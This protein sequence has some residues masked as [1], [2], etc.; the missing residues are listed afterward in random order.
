[1][2]PSIPWNSSVSVFV[3][4][5]TAF[6]HSLKCNVP[7][8]LIVP[9]LSLIAICFHSLSL[10]VLLLVTLCYLF[11]HSL[12]LIVIRY[13]SLSLDV[14]F[15]CLFYKRSWKPLMIKAFYFILKALFILKIFKF[16][17]WLLLMQKNGLIRKRRLIQSFMTSELV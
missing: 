4:E 3:I 10:V 11:Y 6:I 1:M 8:S 9:L 7:F 5:R 14:P 17:S 12:S 13:H 15:V 2:Q 16:L